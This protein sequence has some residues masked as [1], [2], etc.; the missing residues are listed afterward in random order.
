MARNNIKLSVIIPY[1]E[2]KEYTEELLKAL[3]PQ[4]NSE[5]EVLL[6]DDG[7]RE[8][9]KTEYKWC[10]VIRKENGGAGSA[11][12]V[13]IEKSKGKIYHLH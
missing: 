3:A 7:S 6:I 4:V 11:R 1:Y 5:V 9:F 12:N 8:P 13:G 10:K 2:L